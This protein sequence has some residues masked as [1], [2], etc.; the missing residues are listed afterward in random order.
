MGIHEQ[1]PERGAER[2]NGERWD[3][4]L[5]S[6]RCTL[7][8]LRMLRGSHDAEEVAQE[9]L[10]RAWRARQS[11]RTPET[12][13]PWCLQITRNEALRAIGRRR[14][15]SYGECVESVERLADSMAPGEGEGERTLTRLDV[16]R[17]LSELSVEERRL[18][19]LRYTLDY[20]H[21]QIAAELEIPDA[22]ARVRLHRAHKRLA[23]LLAEHG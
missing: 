11:C 22:T 10:A 16:G 8:A 6:R 20:S 19:E 1:L 15:P 5:I 2:S 21:P 4:S 18:L 23:V 7:E 13:L 3:W 12:P 14:T 9:A 17:A